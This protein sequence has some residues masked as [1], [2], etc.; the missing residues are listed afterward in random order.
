[1]KLLASLL[2][3]VVV[4]GDP[5]R[6]LSPF[7]TQ[8]T[9]YLPTQPQM[10]SVRPPPSKRTFNSTAV[11]ALIDSMTERMTDTDLATLFANCWPNTLGSLGNRM[12]WARRSRSPY[13]FRF[14]VLA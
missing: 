5:V 6:M 9:N 4:L 3:V 1:M 13:L 11:N 7:S 14:S 8:P 10:P 2:F 12:L